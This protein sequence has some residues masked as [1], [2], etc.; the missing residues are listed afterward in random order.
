VLA[1]LATSRRPGITIVAA[2]RPDAIRQAYGHWTGVVRRSRLGL[3][4]TGGGDTDGDVLG[5]ALPRRAALPSRPG[6]MW[7]V[8]RGRVVLVQV[9]VDTPSFVDG[10]RT[11]N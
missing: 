2:A 1:A 9:A 11:A 8:D 3:V 5:A 4:A 6:L 10:L 7:L